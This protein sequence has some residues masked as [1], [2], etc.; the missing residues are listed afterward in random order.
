[1]GQCGCSREAAPVYGEHVVQYY[2]HLSGRHWSR[3]GAHRV[4]DTNAR[5]ASLHRLRLSNKWSCLACKSEDAA[6]LDMS[7]GDKLLLLYTPAMQ[8]SDTT[9]NSAA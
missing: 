8:C 9:T 5:Y 6:L 2:H 3:A 1:M 4:A 7:A